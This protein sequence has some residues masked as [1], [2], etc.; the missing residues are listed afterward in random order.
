MQTL[1]EFAEAEPRRGGVSLALKTS[2]TPPP[3]L[4]EKLQHMERLGLPMDEV[5]LSLAAQA[6]IDPLGIF[7]ALRGIGPWAFQ[8]ADCTTVCILDR[9]EK[10]VRAAMSL[11]LLS[12]D[13]SFLARKDKA[14]SVVKVL[15]GETMASWL[16]EPGITEEVILKRIQTCMEETVVVA[17]MP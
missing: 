15:P 1:E 9:E 10:E 8:A 7:G 4:R 12:D 6:P 16:R 3:R 13:L 5:V 14:F 17:R 11:D 2:T